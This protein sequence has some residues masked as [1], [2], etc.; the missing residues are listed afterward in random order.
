[1]TPAASGGASVPP[2]GTAPPAPALSARSASVTVLAQTVARALTLAVVVLS[3]ALVARALPL[4]EYADWITALSLAALLAVLLDLGV[5]GVIVR[6]IAQDHTTAPTPAAMRP[7][8]LALGLLATLLVAGITTA[9]RGTDALALATAL[10]AQLVPRALAMNAMPWL[11]ADHRLHRQTVLEALVGAIGLALIAVT[12]ALDA[13]AWVLALAGFTG[14]I[15]LLAVLVRRELRLTPSARL[16]SPGPQGPKVRSVAH[17]ALP[18]AGAVVLSAIYGR[19]ATI[20]VNAGEDSEGVAR[21]LFAFQFVEQIIVAAGILAGALLPL[22]AQRAR[23]VGLLRDALTHDLNVAVAAAGAIGG[24]VLIALASPLCRVIGGPKLA[25]ADRYLELLAP[26][27]PLLLAAFF[28]GYV[29]IALG[30]GRRYLMFNAAALVFTV[31]GNAALTLRVGAAGAARV[32]W[33]TELLVVV[34]AFAPI[35]R[36]GGTGARAAL[37]IG[38][39][40]AITIAAAELA[41][42]DIV[43]PVLAGAAVI[44]A[45]ALVARREL[46]FVLREVDPRRS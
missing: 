4:T 22:V 38:L 12:V 27:S 41:A 42:A 40:V 13:P 5:S 30:I 33:A 31:A 29:Y 23:T 26:M 39:M 25:P 14:P 28:L 15:T 7:I 45:A 24:G 36:A 3:T 6:R 20:F 2:E 34:L 19:V 11:Q 18:L 16:P 1:M 37:R 21:F 35:A 8:R 17:E 46:L 43:S 32:A 10:G 44:V 9:L